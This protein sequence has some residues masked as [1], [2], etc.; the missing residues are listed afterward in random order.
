MT[1][2][3]ALSTLTRH[4][5]EFR[6]QFGVQRMALFG[7]L[8]RDEGREGSDADVLVEF[9]GGSDFD[10]FMDLKFHLEKLL[11]VRVDLVTEKALRPR[12]RESIE[13]EAIR[14]A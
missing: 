10:R 7:S 8:A 2:R 14:V 3:Q 5:S 1:K 12:L 6:Q 9:S 13:K 4:R 11:G